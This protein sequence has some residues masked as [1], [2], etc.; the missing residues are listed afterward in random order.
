MS[1][2]VKTFAQGNT[3]GNDILTPIE[4]YN[5]FRSSIAETSVECFNEAYE[6]REISNSQRQGVLIQNFTRDN[7]QQLDMIIFRS[8]CFKSI[9]RGTSFYLLSLL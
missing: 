5:V 7:S 2:I 1:S 3:P 9:H 6:R 8:E 4:F